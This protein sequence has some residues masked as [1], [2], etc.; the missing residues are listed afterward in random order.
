ML[1]Q[2]FSIR[3]GI[4]KWCVCCQKTTRWTTERVGRDTE[5]QE[6]SDCGLTYRIEGS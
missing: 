6:C 2:L 3:K 1:K 5:K 4:K